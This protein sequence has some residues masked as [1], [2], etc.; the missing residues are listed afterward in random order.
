MY[1]LWTVLLVNIFLIDPIGPFFPYY[2]HRINRSKNPCKQLS[3]QPNSCVTPGTW[4][5]C[6]SGFRQGLAAIQTAKFS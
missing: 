4:L 6:V 3:K 1:S 5:V 2:T